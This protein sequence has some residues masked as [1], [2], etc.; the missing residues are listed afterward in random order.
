MHH[1]RAAGLMVPHVQGNSYQIVQAPGF[2][3]IRDH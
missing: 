3:A 2:V 1:A